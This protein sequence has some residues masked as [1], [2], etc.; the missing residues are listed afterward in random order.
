MRKQGLVIFLLIL[1]FLV[2]CSSQNSDSDN[3]NTTSL[4]NIPHSLGYINKNRNLVINNLTEGKEQV[5]LKENFIV[6]WSVNT[7]EQLVSYI[8]NVNH[9]G[10]EYSD[11]NVI[12]KNYNT[13]K[14]KI[15]ASGKPYSFLKWSPNGKYLFLF[16]RN[17]AIWGEGEIYDVQNDSLIRI[18]KPISILS[19]SNRNNIW[20]PDSNK[21]ALGIAEEVLP[22]TSMNEGESITTAVLCIENGL[23]IQPIKQGTS[24]VYTEPFSWLNSDTII[25]QS[26]FFS[27]KDK[28]VLTAINITTKEERD[29]SFLEIDGFQLPE[30]VVRY[31][32]QISP[33][34]KYVLYIDSEDTMMLWIV[35][36]D[37]RIQL[38]EGYSFQ[39]L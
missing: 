26:H 31:H 7:H 19:Y 3:K 24:I 28:Q 32:Y 34:K 15:L 20:S 33:D 21:I 23:T 17:N 22:K 18:D 4:Q 12:L 27:G 2:G 6:S 30:D 5:V 13:N 36:T 29:I 14:Q 1:I 16:S 10:N 38:N 37:E 11:T 9:T 35:D 25:V 39:W 8:V